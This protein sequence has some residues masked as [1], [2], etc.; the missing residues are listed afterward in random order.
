METLV[1]LSIYGVDIDFRYG[2]II[3][4][5]ADS[6]T[7]KK[8]HRSYCLAQ[9]LYPFVIS[10]GYRIEYGVPPKDDL[11]S[12][13]QET[14]PSKQQEY[15]KSLLQKVHLALIERMEKNRE[16]AEMML[17]NRLIVDKSGYVY[18]VVSDSG[19][20]KIGKTKYPDDRR[21]TF[22]IKLPF[23]IKFEAL[24]FSEN[25]NRLEKDLHAK[26]T[27][28]RID[29][30]WFDLSADDVEYIKSLDGQVQP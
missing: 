22:E 27:H 26:F 15:A 20:Y 14:I 8:I 7:D 2:A 12:L 25:M 28:K 3:L 23:R 17:A 11:D 29:G 24:I 13:F 30:E 1:N 9:L 4:N 16:V 21:Q 18:L 6:L 19:Y 5:P 10:L